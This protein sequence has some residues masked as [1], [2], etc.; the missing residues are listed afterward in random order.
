MS[1]R[2]TAV[3]GYFLLAL[4][5][6]PLPARAAA[7]RWNNAAGGNWNV[8][9]NWLPAAIPTA[10]DTAVVDLA[11][12]YTVTVNQ[13]LTIAGLRVNGS[14]SG[15]QTV[16]AVSRT[17]AFS[18]PVT[19]GAQ[20]IS[21]WTSCTVSGAG[22]ITSEGTL[23][24]GTS[25]VAQAFTN[26]G[27]LV[28]T[29]ASAQ[30]GALTIAGGSVL[31]VVGNAAANG[32]LTVA[33]GFTNNATIELTSSGAAT[34]ATLAVTAGTLVNAPGG[35]ITSLAGSG[36]GRNLTAQLDNQGTITVS[37]ALSTN[38]ASADHVNS[39]TIDVTGANYT[40]VLSTTTPTFTTTGTINVA[41]SRTLTLQGSLAGGAGM[42]FNYNG[43]TLGGAGTVALLNST[44][45]LNVGLASSMAHLDGTTATVAGPATLTVSAGTTVPMLSSTISAP[46]VVEAGG[47]LEMT[48]SDMVG[49][50]ASSGT[51]VWLNAC[52][53][54]GAIT[55]VAGSVLRVLANASANGSLTV[56]NGFT[57]N[58]TIE[59][60]SS[61]A[62]T[63]ATLAV[64]AGTLVNA[65]AAQINSLAGSSGG[66]NL[67]ARLDNQGTITVSQNLTTNK[68]AVAHTNSGTI[69]VT[70]ANY[71]IILSGTTPSFTT[72][73]AINVAASRTLT[74]QGNISGGAGLNY[75][76]NGGTLGGAGTVALL[77]STLNLNQ[78][79]A[80]SMAH[81]DG[82]TATV[83]GPATLTVSAGTTVP[84]LSS[85][86]SAPTVVEAGGTLEMTASDMV[87]TLASSGTTVWMNACTAP[88]AITTVAGSV[89][90]VLAN[91]SANGSLTVANGFTNNATIE[92]TSSGAA[93]AATLTVT[94]GT[95]VNAPGAQINSLAGSG[96]S[97]L[98]TA[99][100]DNQGTITVS[101]V[102][103]TNKG[104]VDIVNGGTINV[105]GGNYTI[106][107]SGTTPTFTTTGTVNVA[108]SRTLTLQGNIAGG[109]GLDYFY[110]G[111][112][113]S[114]AGTL[115]L[116]N[117]TLRLNQPL[118]TSAVILA[119]SG[120]TITG[121]DTLRV[122]GGSPSLT[123][124]TMNGPVVCSG[125]TLTANG[126]DWNALLDMRP[127]GTLVWNGASTFAGTF[128][129]ASGSTTRLMG[130]AGANSTLTATVP[131]QNNGLLELG[132]AG[133]TAAILSLNG[134]FTNGPS[135][136][137]RTL[138][139]GGGA[140]QLL[141]ALDNQG[142]CDAQQTLLVSRATSAHANS[143][144]VKVAA[145]KTLTFSGASFT[146]APTG[147]LAGDG[148]IAMSGATALAQSG[149]VRPGAS[150]GR[151]S[152]TATSYPCA[153]TSV[154][155]VEVGGEAPATGHDQVAISGAAALAGTLN[156]SLVNGFLP[157]PGRR[158][159]IATFASR[160]GT[161]GTVT[162]L[163]YGPGQ[164]WAVAYTDTDVVLLA[165][166]QTWTRLFPQGTPPQARD[167]HAAVLDST[168]DR[169][170]VF[171]GRGD[172]G[173]LNDV[174]VLTHATSGSGS[175]W[176]ALS[177]TGT[178]P[179]ARTNASAVY[180]PAT[181]RMIVY[182][183]DDAAGTP[184]PF[185][186]AWVL[187]NANGLGG[188][189]AWT[190][191]APAS[192][193]PARTAHGAA[194][195]PVNNRMMLFGGTT[196]LGTCGGAL[197][198]AWVL[199]NANGLG[200]APAWTLVI[201]GP[202]G[203]TMPSARQF[204][205]T[206]YDVATARLVVTGGED[207]CG[208]PN[209]QGWLLDGAN[210][211]S[212]PAVW[213][214]IGAVTLA[215]DGWSRAR[216][217]YDP[218]YKWI[219][220]FGGKFG[221]TYVDTSWTLTGAAGGGGAGWV[222]RLFHGTRPPAR[223]LHS[224][225]LSGGNHVAVVFGGLTAAGRV[226]DVHRRDIDHGPVLG[227]DPPVTPPSALP[228]VTAFAMPPSPNPARGDVALAV[229]VARDQRV[230]LDVFDLAGRR[231]ASLHSGLL[232][233]GRHAF[234][235][236]GAG[237]RGAA[238]PGVY[239]VRMHAEE[240]TQVVRVVRIR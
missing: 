47:T 153:P 235:W 15:T 97:R 101:Q 239:L 168:G 187:T 46:T 9:A 6:L 51:T 65:P 169:M 61:G 156:I 122:D 129:S 193:P 18:G 43:G 229:D 75:H 222:R 209:T 191:L 145:T 31:R 104:S 136:T 100:Y 143:G 188:A 133:A 103:T 159:V 140:R 37:Q 56:A 85:T 144:T 211:L 127:G 214:P 231:V 182:G 120:A 151:L 95:L 221:A 39:G 135:G 200:G 83:D 84:M 160:T 236:S 139:N 4:A 157:T 22:A 192:A 72:T 203:P 148:T 50:L 240:R 119:G 130:T 207:G 233:A 57:N 232:A 96:G 90:R 26:A 99:Q 205:G 2:P 158:Y 78:P 32:Q 176:I 204:H 52:T 175:Q 194:Y 89:L 138:V 230:E 170:I 210:G 107:L 79:L 42:N 147:V 36:G 102:T 33:N 223:E 5:L 10:S 224:M 40:I 212:G 227:V 16:T 35:Q 237:E 29:G 225:I 113:L 206:A 81:L 86:I 93:T 92:L 167:G 7:V 71:T 161:F 110:N 87:G 21:N 20:S 173:P 82:T 69:N 34:A 77:N 121:P 196:T 17:M 25:T 217:A 112:T 154:H 23:N 109:A 142:L 128:V 172:A 162:G 216:F 131:M 94:A 30:N 220:A 44:L 118:A 202:P 41:A 198:D 114:G 137:M 132:T 74:L 98:L 38:K 141:C 91:A 53:A 14:A 11:G 106:V 54:P 68:A 195:D 45:N 185:G 105:T 24:L 228:R 48:A 28:V 62:A 189:P 58:A 165:L 126:C 164:M 108:A 111:G 186:D 150:P 8:P 197:A 155:D 49:T 234:R 60:T 179:A 13:N 88:G 125:G 70:G 208:T 199:A 178:P 124:C 146:N 190:A 63:A 64:T 134:T 183:G 67:N 73:G 238:S 66:R 117:S 27:T 174:W 123:N 59:L 215:P 184:V 213:T 181:N 3:A 55:T 116:L 177:P 149:T 171:G 226:N 201:S 1:R 19:L 219:D 180:D 115:S 218:V 12:T 152:F 80:S 76:Y 163:E 166:D